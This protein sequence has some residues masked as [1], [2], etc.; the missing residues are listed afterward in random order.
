M[1]ITFLGAARTVT[2]SCYLIEV[3]EHKILLDCGM[4]QGSKLV[5]SF[6]EK[7]FMFAPNEIEAVVLTHAHVDHSGL[8]PKLCKQGY[9]GPVHC[10]KSTLEL[11]SILLP[12]SA[13][14]QESDAEL[15]MRKNQRL[16][17]PANPPL[18]SL[19]DAFE[20]LKLFKVHDFED[21]FTVVPGIEVNLK[22]A[23]HI[24]GSAIVEMKITEGDKVTKLIFTGDIGQPNQ[25]IIEDPD[26]LIG[27]DF[28]VT[29]STY[30]NRVHEA[31]DKEG[32]L[33]K[34]INETVDKGGNVIIPA[35]AVGRTQV[36]LYYFQKMLAEGKIPEVPIYVDSPMANKATQ[37]TLTNPDEYDEE[38][39]ALYD[40]QGNHLVSMRNLHFTAT[41]QE[42]QAINSMEGS[43]II[44]SASG[45]A[46]AGRI[47]HHLKHNL[48][49]EDSCVVFAGYQAEG[50]IG[51]KLTEGSKKVK[52]MG[53]DIVVRAKIYNMKG[54]SAHA[55]KEQLLTW[56]GAMKKMPKCFFVTHGEV[57]AA[58]NLA[59]EIRRRLGLAAYVPK[60]GDCVEISGNEYRIEE[61]DLMDAQESMLEA[62]QYLKQMESAY[63]QQKTRLEQIVARDGD[64][65]DLVRKKMEKLRRYMDDLLSDIQ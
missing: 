56:F 53:E 23:G 62:Q 13:H 30:G 9:K 24:L 52:I 42:S 44:I 2:G 32:E 64:K 63:L 29:E 4:F 22:K 19:D 1:K 46:D 49:R 47:L 58:S 14:I 43:K 40:M 25:P 21:S 60:F 17:K 8:I 50:S 59:D 20:A 7:E 6:N 34:I 15:L 12:D 48:W 33:E 65:A 38:A 61:S 18:F 57:D 10:T 51:R 26:A 31:Y 54:F 5:K 16:G 37:I 27:A 28:V 11:C 3:G 55:D 36:L 35:F 45:M 41:A 39:R